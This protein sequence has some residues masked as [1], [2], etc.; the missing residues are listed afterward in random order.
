MK[1]I[2][3][4]LA[5]INNAGQKGLHSTL[6]C[7]T[8]DVKAVHGFGIAQQNALAAGMKV[9][10]SMASRGCRLVPQKKHLS[11]QSYAVSFSSLVFLFKVNLYFGGCELCYFPIHAQGRNLNTAL[12]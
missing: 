10:P 2:P 11:E 9:R 3:L 8:M 6:L 12:L 4:C 7:C 1:P 5:S